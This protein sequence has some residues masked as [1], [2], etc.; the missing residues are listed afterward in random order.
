MGEGPGG[1]QAAFHK[2]IQGQTRGRKTSRQKAV[3]DPA[4]VVALA[5]PHLDPIEICR[6]DGHG[7]LGCRLRC[8]KALAQDLAQVASVTGLKPAHHK[9]IADIGIGP[10]CP[11]WPQGQETACPGPDLLEAPWLIPTGNGVVI[12]LEGP[13]VGKPGLIGEE[14]AQ[15]EPLDLRAVQIETR[16]AEHRSRDQS[17]RRK[18]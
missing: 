7:R 15:A 18:H 10:V 4:R 11:R 1:Q 17:G 3:I 8:Q 14:M 12:G 16:F 5:I 2:T 6:T 13:V 9:T